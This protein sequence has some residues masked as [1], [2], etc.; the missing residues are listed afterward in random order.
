MP[1]LSKGHEFEYEK[2]QTIIQ[3]RE[4]LA[5]RAALQ[6]RIK[7]E[8]ETDQLTQESERTSREVEFLSDNL[9]DLM[10]KHEANRLFKEIIQS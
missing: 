10:G 2:E 3:L 4:A 7:V 5:H 1:D 8:G 6:Q 9:E